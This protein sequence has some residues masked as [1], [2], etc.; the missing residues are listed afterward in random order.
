MA[1]RTEPPDLILHLELLCLALQPFPSSIGPRR[2]PQDWSGGPGRGSQISSYAYLCLGERASMLGVQEAF[3]VLPQ[4]GRFGLDSLSSRPT[5][6]PLTLVTLP[7]ACGWGQH[8][9]LLSFW[10]P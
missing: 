8:L 1:V 4:V 3:A 2:A 10:M 5:L 6:K 9:G 7:Q